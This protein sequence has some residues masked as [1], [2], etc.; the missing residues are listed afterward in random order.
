MIRKINEYSLKPRYDSSLPI[1]MTINWAIDENLLHCWFALLRLIHSSFGWFSIFLFVLSL[2]F[3]IVFSIYYPF[4]LILIT[5]IFSI[6]VMWIMCISNETN[7]LGHITHHFGRVQSLSDLKSGSKCQQVI[8]MY[9]YIYMYLKVSCC[10]QKLENSI[11]SKFETV[12]VG[13]VLHA[14]CRTTTILLLRLS[15]IKMKP[16]HSAT[17]HGWFR[18]SISETIQN[19]SYI[20]TKKKKNKWKTSKIANWHQQ[21]IPYIHSIVKHIILDKFV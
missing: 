2:L 8:H 4:Y 14:F 10:S 11:F 9:I 16:K 3:T 15:C 17:V 20:W 21:H 13:K 7:R 12:L 6:I 1:S 18:L 19:W 5:V